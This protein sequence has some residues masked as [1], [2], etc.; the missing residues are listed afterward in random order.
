L[1]GESAHR[2]ASIY[3]GQQ[4]TQKAG[5]LPYLER[6]SNPRRQYASAPKH[7]SHRQRGH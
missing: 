6:N 2:K 7:T 1:D 4:N 3:T 5:M